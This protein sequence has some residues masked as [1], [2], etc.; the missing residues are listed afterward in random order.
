MI[1]TPII[2]LRKIAIA[3]HSLLPYLPKDETLRREYLEELFASGWEL[4]DPLPQQVIEAPI[5][6]LQRTP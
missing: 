4:G 6:E 3:Y 5:K 1:D 2:K